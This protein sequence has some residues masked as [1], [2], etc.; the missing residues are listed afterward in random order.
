MK[1]IVVLI[2]AMSLNLNSAFAQSEIFKIVEQM[3]R[4]P[5][6]EDLDGNKK[7]KEECSKDKMLDYIYENLEYPQM[8]ID[9][10]K[11]GICVAQFVVDTIGHIGEIRLVRDMGYGS[12]EIVRELIE[13]MNHM[14]QKWTAGTQRGR[15]VHVL[16]TL[17]VYFRFDG[18]RG[19]RVF[20][21]ELKKSK[22]VIIY[23]NSKESDSS[24]IKLYQNNK[25]VLSIKNGSSKT[26]TVAPGEHS[27]FIRGKKKESDGPALKLNLQKGET[28]YLLARP[29]AH[30]AKDKYSKYSLREVFYVTGLEKIRDLK[31]EK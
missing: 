13:S 22:V 21:S 14:P 16:Y 29:Y 8:A 23:D 9:S 30:R 2:L 20:D 15:P 12:G 10:L 4:F 24:D 17:P 5:G 26:Y 31:A 7:A 3:P 19:I 11:E 28:A 6:C 25:K 27:L 1:T 18:R